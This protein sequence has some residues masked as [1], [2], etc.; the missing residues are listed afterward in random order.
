M[1]HHNKMKNIFLHNRRQVVA[2]RFSGLAKCES[3][4]LAILLGLCAPSLSRAQTTSTWISETITNGT[5]VPWSTAAKWG[6]TA[7]VTNGGT[8]NLN[9]GAL[10]VTTN[11]LALNN[12]IGAFDINQ[13]TLGKA[14]GKTITYNGTAVNW[15]KDGSSN[16][17]TIILN[18][19]STSENIIGFNSSIGSGVTL[20][21]TGTSS[22]SIRTSGI[23]SGLGGVN[24]DKAG[25]FVAQAGH[26]FSGGFTL[27]NG[28]VTLLTNTVGSPGSVTSGPLGKGNL[29]LNGG[30][31]QN[32]AL[33]T[34]ANNVQVGGNFTVGSA[35][36]NGS[37]TLSGAVL[38]TGT[39]VTRTITGGFTGAVSAGNNTL[40]L[41]GNITEAGAGNG[42]LFNNTSVTTVVLSGNNTYTGNTIVNGGNLTL[43]DN[44]GLK[45]VIGANGVNNQLT[46]TGTVQLDGDFTFDLSGAGTALGNSWNI[47]NVAGL[48][49][50]FAGTFT[51]SGF[52]D[53]GGNLWEATNVNGGRTYQFSE[54]TGL[55]SVTAVPEPAT[56]ALLAFSL[57]TV[58][59][60]RRRRSS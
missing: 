12:D 10:T 23:M 14:T 58:M 50:T 52:N 26:T 37:I 47:V 5:T 38:L 18:N 8:V 57:T 28:T 43:S 44:A 40:T 32:S 30:T 60:L 39:G 19:V 45:F 35:T 2:S 56:W 55:L 42:L 15:V 46:G 21:I 29:I 53:I 3:L 17:P 48:A 49:E 22:G 6:G 24:L 33:H 34:L 1:S 25:T 20:Q 36:S 13:M 31:L 16:N 59:V 27:A 9:F 41:S 51:V 54:A 7:P 4:L 11:N